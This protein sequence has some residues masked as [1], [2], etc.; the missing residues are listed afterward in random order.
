MVTDHSWEA[1]V[2]DTKA[3]PPPGFKEYYDEKCEAAYC[4]NPEKRE[5]HSYDNV[6][7][8]KA[9]CEYVKKHNLGGILVWEL[10]ADH[11]VTDHRSL[12]KVMHDELVVNRSPPEDPAPV[13]DPVPVPD[14][15]PPPPPSVPDPKPS[16]PEEPTPVPDPVPSPLPPPSVPDPKPS[17]PEEPSPVP[18]PP[19][20]PVIGQ[21]KVKT[22]RYTGRVENGV[23]TGVWD[24][25]YY[26]E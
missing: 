7:S 21:G 24:Y 18:V 19:A 26:N 14:P 6:R 16:P 25:E 15:S 10:S 2:L 9:K 13:P 11:P 22:V 4:Y 3:I 1:G 23:T 8:V 20:P 17:P 12:V 5:Y